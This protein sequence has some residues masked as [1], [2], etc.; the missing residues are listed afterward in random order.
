METKTQIF[1]NPNLLVEALGSSFKESVDSTV[2]RGENMN[3]VIPGGSTPQKFFQFL[4]GPIAKEIDW[5]CVHLY[6]GDERCVPPDHPESNYG[7]T[8]KALLDKINIPKRNIHRIHGEDIP[9]QEVQRYSDEIRKFVPEDSHSIPRFDWIILGLGEDGHTASLFPNLNLSTTS[10][11][12]CTIA[13][14][15]QSGQ[16]RISLTLSAI[17]NAKRVSF[18]VSGQSKGPIVASIL[19]CD[20]ESLN[21][22]ASQ[23][24]PNSGNLEWFID[25][26]ASSLL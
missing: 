24:S 23:V 16:K 6:W 25:S 7:M 17:N 13:S 3:I 22:P 9:E 12:I 5:N 18:L 20:R 4:S 14:H 1:A 10:E 21:L 2:S 19:N 15:P 26:S 11:Q 8:H